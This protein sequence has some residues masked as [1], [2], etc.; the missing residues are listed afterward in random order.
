MTILISV[1]L[2]NFRKKRKLDFINFFSFFFYF[3]S[4]LFPIFPPWF[5]TLQPWF[6]AFPPP[7]SPHSHSV[8]YSANKE[9]EFVFRNLKSDLNNALAWFNINSLKANPGRFQFMVLGTKEAD[10]FVLNI[11][12]NK[13]WSSTEITLLG[14]NIDK[15]I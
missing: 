5:L 9:L 11:G 10:S 1:F 15:F 2:L 3:C 13:I 4:I 7:H 6:P 8:L 12:K 14:V